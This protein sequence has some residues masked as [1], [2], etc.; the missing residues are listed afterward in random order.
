MANLSSTLPP[1][2]RE[3]EAGVKSIDRAARLLQALAQS[4]L[5][6]GTLTDVARISGLGKPTTH[7][8]LAALI[9]V[10]FVFQEPST[11]RYRL[12]SRLA[13]LGHAAHRQDFA[14]LAHPFI[15]RIAGTTGDTVYASV[16]EGAA[17]VCVDRAIGGFPIRTLSLEVGH[18]RPLGVGS[19]SLALLASLPGDEVE[20]ALEKNR[21]WL[22]SYPTMDREVIL[23][24]VAQSRERGYALVE[25]LILPG[26][27][28][29]GVPVLDASGAPFAALS[30]A[31]IADRMPSRRI[32]EL[33]PML[34]TAARELATADGVGVRP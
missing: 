16:R 5:D 25:G 17:A 12:G 29:V 13:A 34:K 18:R 11:R 31:A 28:A 14:A 20:R 1:A 32:A 8:L 15:S 6:G 23:R 19:G 21:E 27:H 22:K 9:D 30:I 3:S 33:V 26:M 10:G 7:R 24:M 4:G 2:E